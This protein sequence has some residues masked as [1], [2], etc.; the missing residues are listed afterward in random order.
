[1]R[2]RNY[3]VNRVLVAV[4]VSLVLA[5]LHFGLRKTGLL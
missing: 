1:M 3:I 4:I 5:I 2:S